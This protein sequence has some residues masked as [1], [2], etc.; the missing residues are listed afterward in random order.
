MPP[1]CARTAI[2]ESHYGVPMAGAVLNTINTRLDAD[3]VAFILEHA[4][5]KV[6]LTDREFSP[7]V[8]KA[9]RARPWVK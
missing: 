1:A 5:T 8:G 6:L 9:L 7:L 3:T 4:E 2:L